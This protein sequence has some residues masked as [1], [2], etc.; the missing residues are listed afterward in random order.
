[1]KNKQGGNPPTTFNRTRSVDDID[2]PTNTTH[3]SKFPCMICKDDHLLRDFPGLTKILEVWST[4]S[5]H[6]MSPTASSN[7]GDNPSNSNIK[8]GSKKSR[9]KYPCR[10]CE[11]IHQTYLFHRMDEA[12]HLLENIVDF[13]QQLPT[14]Y[15]KFSPNLPLVDEL[16][17]IV[18]SS[19]NLVDQV[20]DQ[21]HSSVD[22]T[23]P[24]ESEVQVVDLVPLLVVNPT[25]S[26]LE[27]EAHVV[28]LIPPSF[29]L[30]LPLKSEVGIA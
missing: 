18:P 24:S 3:K 27:I 9:V 23:L 28:N 20:I 10:L 4:G 30:T 6:P 16:I 25:L 22:P 29:D 5:Q 21:I 14:T 12:S 17:N 8:V 2:K 13:Q 7:D 26:S 11:G 1:M 19:V 15:H